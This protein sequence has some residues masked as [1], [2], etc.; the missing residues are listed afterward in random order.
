MS[1]APDPF[2]SIVDPESPPKGTDK[3]VGRL[4][5]VPESELYFLANCEVDGRLGCESTMT[6]E[7]R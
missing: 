1:P 3:I 2:R 7:A 6:S 4:I 5:D